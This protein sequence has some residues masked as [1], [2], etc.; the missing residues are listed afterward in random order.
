[1]YLINI[2]VYGKLSLSQRRIIYRL[3]SASSKQLFSYIIGFDIIIV[4]NRETTI[5]RSQFPNMINDT[6]KLQVTL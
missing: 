1:V 6:A 4:N 5:S 2:K 3:V